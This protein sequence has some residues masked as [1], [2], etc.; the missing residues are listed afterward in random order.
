MQ[1]D[2]P[3]RS[4]AMGSAIK[5]ANFVV[6][7][8]TANDV[9]ESTIRLPDFFHGNGQMC[10]WRDCEV[11]RCVYSVNGKLKDSKD[12]VI[13]QNT[14]KGVLPPGLAL[15]FSGRNGSIYQE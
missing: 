11:V 5:P 2:P 9:F 6:V 8:L 13:I 15:V 1:A 14:G 10:K 12:D 4:S 7:D 3:N